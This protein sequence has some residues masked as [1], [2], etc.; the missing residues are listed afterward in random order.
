MTTRP[1]VVGSGM[2]TIVRAGA[3]R[4][5]FS[6]DAMMLFPF[7]GPSTINVN[8][9][10]ELP[11]ITDLNSARSSVSWNRPMPLRLD[12]LDERPGNRFS[13]FCQLGQ[14]DVLRNQGIRIEGF[15]PPV[16]SGTGGLVERAVHPDHDVLSG[17][18]RIIDQVGIAGTGRLINIPVGVPQRVGNV[19]LPDTQP[20]RRAAPGTGPARYS[21][22]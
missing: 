22:R 17:G 10:F 2:A 14:V 13:H 15:M 7:V 11:V 18:I 9:S 4:V 12:V 19:L 16:G 21:W 1:K 3:A 8:S 5:A 20:H 6:M